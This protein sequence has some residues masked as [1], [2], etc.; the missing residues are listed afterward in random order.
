MKPLLDFFYVYENSLINAIRSEYENGP[1][2]ETNI[3]AWRLTRELRKDFV[4]ALKD[5]QN[6]ADR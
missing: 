5:V 2:S 3:Q 4:E 1:T 6:A